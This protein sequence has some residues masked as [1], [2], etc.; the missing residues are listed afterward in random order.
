MSAE[1]VVPLSKAIPI[2]YCVSKA[3]K[4]M[5]PNTTVG[6]ILQQSLVTELQERFG[7]LERNMMAVMAIIL[8]PRFKDL[9]FNDKTSIPNAL[10]KMSELILSTSPPLAVEE[11][12]D[13]EEPDN[14][15]V[16]HDKIASKRKHIEPESESGISSKMKVYFKSGLENRNEDVLSVWNRI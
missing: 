2:I 3:L 4:S 13:E 10:A 6:C 12:D 8:D 5:E 1:K 14:F 15:W 11:S 7:G 16:H 9:D